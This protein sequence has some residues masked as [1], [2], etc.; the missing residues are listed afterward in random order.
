M[1]L[2]SVTITPNKPM[3]GTSLDT[4]SSSSEDESFSRDLETTWSSNVT[5]EIIQQLTDAEKKRQEIINGKSC[6]L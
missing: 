6:K 2:S 5:Q 1:N 4:S 3:P